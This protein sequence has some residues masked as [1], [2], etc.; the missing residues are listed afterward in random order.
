ME[1]VNGDG[2]TMYMNLMPLK[3]TT[4][5]NGYYDASYYVYF[6]IFKILNISLKSG[7]WKNW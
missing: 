7:L 4:L 6:T 1:M 2:C 5:K 3:F